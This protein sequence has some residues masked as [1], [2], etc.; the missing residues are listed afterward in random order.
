MERSKGVSHALQEFQISLLGTAGVGKT[1][2]VLRYTKNEFSPIYTPNLL[3]NVYFRYSYGGHSGVLRILDP[4]GMD[5]YEAIFDQYIQVSV[6]FLVVFAIDNYESFRK[7]KDLVKKI[8]RSNDNAPI[9]LVGNKSDLS[10]FRAV[11]SEHIEKILDQFDDI[12]YLET[13]CRTGKNVKEAF[14]KL[15][16]ELQGDSM[17]NPKEHRFN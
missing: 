9:I 7:A 3:D 12:K 4:S 8:N 2:L 17:L 15:I 11:D 13:S 14:I 1:S 6:G 5:H 10:D 16:R